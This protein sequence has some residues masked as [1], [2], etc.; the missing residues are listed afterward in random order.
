MSTNMAV[1]DGTIL[2]SNQPAGTTSPDV[3]SPQV[4]R[5]DLGE[6][7]AYLVPPS[8]LTIDL[9][10]NSRFEEP[11]AKKIKELAASF[12][13]QGQLQPI[14]VVQA[15]KSLVVTFGFHR[16]LAALYGI[17]HGM[18]PRDFKIRYELDDSPDLKTAFLAS[19]T[20]NARRNDLTL[21]DKAVIFQRLTEQHGLNKKDAAASL[22]QSK[23]W[24]S[25]IVG[26][27]T[28]PKAYQRL[29]H[30]GRISGQVGYELS[31]AGDAGY[32]I[33]DKLLSKTDGVITTPMWRDAWRARKDQDTESN[34]PN[35]GAQAVEGGGDA[36]PGVVA[37]E[38]GKRA[39]KSG[40]GPSTSRNAAALKRFLEA[41]VE[42]QEDKATGG[43]QVAKRL[44]GYMEGKGSDATMGKFLDTLAV[45]K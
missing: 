38:K 17:E 35:E 7:G 10:R 8:L 39:T 11:D 23:Q 6:A 33:L 1:L 14:K 36:D 3:E 40:D 31:I 41:Y 5:T 32:P 13:D 21:M 15:D 44:K 26:L 24:A 4:K 2:P 9:S 18:L 22:G 19:V 16:A 27:L 42:A 37:K 45:I 43:C 34:L 20:E 30:R 12:A 25:S 28:L 29:V